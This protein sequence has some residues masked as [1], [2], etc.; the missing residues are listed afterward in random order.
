MAN[1]NRKNCETAL[2]QL[3]L[4]DKIQV[5]VGK[6]EKQITRLTLG[7]TSVSVS[8]LYRVDEFINLLENSLKVNSVASSKYNE[9]N[10]P[11]EFE[12][13]QMWIDR[14]ATYTKKN[15]YN[16]KTST[17]NEILAWTCEDFGYTQKRIEELYNNWNNDP[18]TKKKVTIK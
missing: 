3:G 12:E 5:T 7:N 10:A 6:N 18:E 14:Q 8:A 16:Y 17:L 4:Q 2:T 11:N 13:L 1:N 9:C 15:I